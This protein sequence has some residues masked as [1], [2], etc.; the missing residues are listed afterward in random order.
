MHFENEDLSDWAGDVRK[1]VAASP[2]REPN[3][4]PQELERLSQ[5]IN[6]LE[7]SIWDRAQN[8]LGFIMGP[9]LRTENA[10]PTLA[11][12]KPAPT[13][14]MAVEMVIS[15]QKRLDTFV[16][17]MTAVLDRVQL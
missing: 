7:G 15:M 12:I 8:K 9:D 13:E 10:T 5:M 6:D 14:A 3:N 11:D 2:R 17:E 1:S 16:R 4:L